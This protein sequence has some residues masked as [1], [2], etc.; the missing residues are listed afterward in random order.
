MSS[1]L[2]SLFGKPMVDP[3][4]T[5]EAVWDEADLPR[6]SE[7][8]PILCKTCDSD[9]TSQGIVNKP[10][11]IGAY[12]HGSTSPPSYYKLSYH[13]Q[14]GL[15]MD[16]GGYGLSS[17][18]TLFG[19]V[20]DGVTS[21]GVINLNAA[22]QFSE[23]ILRWLAQHKGRFAS[24]D[25]PMLKEEVNNIFLQATSFKNNRQGEHNSEGG[26]ATVALCAVIKR[27]N[28]ILLMGASI[29][30]ASCIVLNPDGT[31]SFVTSYQRQGT[32][33]KDTGGQITMCMGIH[34]DVRPFIREIHRD[35]KILLV[36]DGVTDNITR[37]EFGTMLN[38]I[39]RARL[40][41]EEQ[42]SEDLQMLPHRPRTQSVV[43]PR[44]GGR[45]KQRLNSL[46]TPSPNLPSV[47][48]MVRMCG[49][50]YADWKDVSCL[51]IVVRITHYLKWATLELYLQEETFFKSEL[52]LESCNKKLMSEADT[53]SEDEKE[54]LKNDISDLQDSSKRM[55]RERKEQLHA[56]KTDDAMVIAFNPI[57]K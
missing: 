2:S 45:N 24:M 28:K 36:T 25:E 43:I 7:G 44:L 18:G 46:P 50:D 32:S 57:W 10:K 48:E 34:G 22:Q 16:R 20:C 17:D 19:V 40:F 9:N 8:Y 55:R 30:D 31:P 33:A 37:R 13:L 42:S 51:D 52:K 26:S 4:Q 6:D 39:M 56:A 5:P 23:Y 29:G 11:D 3:S 14:E 54:K 1:W 27:G 15:N 38:L 47:E 53:L 49:E 21:G 41:N 12:F 35:S